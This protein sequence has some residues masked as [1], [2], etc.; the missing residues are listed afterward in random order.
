MTA[1]GGLQQ[2]RVCK[3][4]IL[5]GLRPYLG[6]M[7]PVARAVERGKLKMFYTKPSTHLQGH[8]GEGEK[9]LCFGCSYVLRSIAFR[10]PLNTEQK[11][12]IGCACRGNNP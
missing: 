4:S 10:P 2:A 1:Q 12:G 7:D 5:V 9:R 11:H 3:L 6:I 8:V